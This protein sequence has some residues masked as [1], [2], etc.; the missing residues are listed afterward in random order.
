MMLHSVAMLFACMAHVRYLVML[1]ICCKLF[2][3]CVYHKYRYTLLHHE[4]ALVICDCQKDLIKA[5][6][7]LLM[8]ATSK[9]AHYEM[10]EFDHWRPSIKLR[11]K[12]RNRLRKQ[13]IRGVLVWVVPS[14]QVL[15]PSVIVLDLLD[16]YNRSVTHATNAFQ[17]RYNRLSD[18]IA[19][20]DDLAAGKGLLGD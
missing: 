19:L 11:L 5:K 15:E 14:Q 13:N 8:F 12:S 10:L 1:L 20:L 6:F 4:H 9:L 17:F 16:C 3:V 18:V 2:L 7:N